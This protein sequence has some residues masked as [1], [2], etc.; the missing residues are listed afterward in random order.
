MRCGALFLLLAGAGIVPAAAEPWVIP[1][2]Q[3][4]PGDAELDVGG[5]A[6]GAAFGASGNGGSAHISGAAKLTARLHRDYDSG[7]SLG[8]NTT[9]TASDILS[10]G[11]YGGDAVEQAYGE[12]RIGFGRIEIGQVDGAGYQLAVSGPKVDA[13]VSLDDPQT[14]FFRDP[15]THRAFTDSFAL[16]SQV[17]ASSNYA[18][19]VFVSTNLLG[20][21]LAVS[22]TPNQGKDLL[23][24]LREGAHIPGRQAD[25][26]EGAIKYSDDLGPVSLTAY[27]GAAEGRAEHK[28]A[29]QEGVSDLAAGLRA[30][31]S[32]NDDLT[33][34]L[35]GAWRQSNA[36][37]FQIE[38]S[39]KSAT[40]RVL[41][42]S[43]ALT[44][45][46]WMLGVEFGDGNA[47][48]VTGAPLIALTGYQ[49]SIGYN[50]SNSI[51]LSAGWQRLNYE[52]SSGTFYNGRPRI[53]LDA[54]FLHLSLK[55]SQ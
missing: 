6:G 40:T 44:Y 15:S 7:L 36:Y 35:G 53:A 34:S 50:F 27:A 48:K 45:D 39:F 1:S 18:K 46:S 30:D 10:R 12:A 32:L 47:G 49:S 25:I 3:Y 31:Y 26:W 54:G 4:F 9:L 8:F 21:Q 55:T 17:G 52:R 43:A 24:F 19:F 41:Q 37:A 42:S 13:A 5:Q 23:P 38:R 33:L 11:R 2:A 22:F 29:G 14:T 28:P 20:A 51:Q 16:R